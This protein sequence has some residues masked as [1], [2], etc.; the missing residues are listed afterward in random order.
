MNI[1]LKP[2]SKLRRTQNAQTVFSKRFRGN[3]TQDALLDVST[4]FVW[5]D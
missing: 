1:K 3:R 5:I 4:P 2:G